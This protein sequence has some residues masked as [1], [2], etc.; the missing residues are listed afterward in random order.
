MK[1]NLFLVGALVLLCCSCARNSVLSDTEA[2]LSGLD[3]EY[4]LGKSDGQK[5]ETFGDKDS[6]QMLKDNYMAEVMGRLEVSKE[7]VMRTA[8][9]AT[10]ARVGVFRVGSCG[11]Y[12][13][14][15]VRI[16]GENG[17][18]KTRVEGNVGNNFVDGDDNMHLEFCLVEAGFQYP[19][20]VFL[21]ENAPT[22]S[23]IEPTIVRYHDTEDGGHQ[24][25]WSD[26]P[27]YSNGKLT[28]ITGLSKLDSNAA[29]AWSFNRN[30]I[31]DGRWGTDPLPF[32][33][34]GI[35][36]GVVAPSDFSS[37][38][39]YFDDE[40]HNNK[41]WAQLWSLNQGP[42]DIRGEYYGVELGIN[43]KYHI[44]LSTDKAN[45]TKLVKS[46][47]RP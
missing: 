37:G 12:K 34:I 9:S 8:Y 27:K 18:S 31:D 39:L 38:S 42:R 33:P 17:N 45:F 29:L 6:I 26:D 41:N 1:K 11:N 28:N 30:I 43:T 5:S 10:S 13:F 35:N 46:V 19:G 4:E 24:G 21:V 3:D 7:K 25:I 32:G 14:L 20:G 15:S 16:D 36:Y 40:D 2:D 44:C 47:V 23:N 22:L